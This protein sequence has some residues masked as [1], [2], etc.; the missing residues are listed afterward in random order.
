MGVIAKQI[1][2]RANRRLAE[3][4]TTTTQL[5]TAE[6]TQAIQRYCQQHNKRA[7]A[8]VTRSRAEAGWFSKWLESGQ[9]ERAQLARERA[10]H[11]HMVVQQQSILVGFQRTP[12]HIMADKRKQQSASSG[13]WLAAVR[14]PTPPEALPAGQRLVTVSLLKWVMDSNGI[15]KNQS[16]YEQ[17]TNALWEAVSVDAK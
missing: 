7:S 17:F 14:F 12:Q 3:P 16:K 15:V 6:V 5:T 10:H 11:Y 2:K 1:R 8:V 13:Y 4:L 9:S